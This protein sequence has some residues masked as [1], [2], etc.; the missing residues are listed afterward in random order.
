MNANQEKQQKIL[1][2]RLSAILAIYL[3]LG[4]RSIIGAVSSYHGFAV[5][6]IRC[7]NA[8]DIVDDDDEDEEPENNLQTELLYAINILDIGQNNSLEDGLKVFEATL[9]KYKNRTSANIT[10]QEIME[11]VFLATNIL[12]EFV[13]GFAQYHLNNTTP[14]LQHQ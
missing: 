4:S 2:W 8:V 11:E 3:I 7:K 10:E 12:E 6:I 5:N 13:L 9:A 14:K 1:Q